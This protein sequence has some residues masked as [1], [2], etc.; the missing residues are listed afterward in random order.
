MRTHYLRKTTLVLLV[1][2]VVLGT[3]AAS[4]SSQNAASA[5]TTFEFRR[6]LSLNQLHSRR[7]TDPGFHLVG[8]PNTWSHHRSRIYDPLW[9]LLPKD[10]SLKV[11]KTNYEGISI[12]RN[13]GS[14][15]GKPANFLPR[16]NP[17][18]SPMRVN[19]PGRPF[20]RMTIASS[21]LLSSIFT[22]KSEA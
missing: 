16:T 1:S 18:N 17:A 12:R 3:V 19:D 20:M 5:E 10:T 9:A 6:P 22:C 7:N 14:A 13:E 2:L 21:S 8:W 4:C 15:H 11:R